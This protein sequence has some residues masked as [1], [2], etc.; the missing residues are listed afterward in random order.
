MQITDRI[1]AITSI[2]PAYR[3]ALLPAP[4]SVKIE[5]TGRCNF[6]CSFCARSMKL[7]GQFDMDRGLFERL[8]L[9]MREAGVEELGL[10]YLG[11]SMLLPWLAEACAFAKNTA[12]FPYVFLTTN[13]SLASPDKCEALFR[14]GLDSLKFSLNYADSDQFSEIARVKPKLYH[15]MIANIKAV[16][17]VRDR[18][19]IDT[20]HRCGLYAS[21]IEYDGAQGERMKS[22]VNEL[23]GC[24][25]QIYGLPLYSQAELVGDKERDKGWNVTAGN[26]GRLDAL[27]EPL[28]CWSVFT[29]GHITWD[30]KLS[31]CCFDHDGR[32]EMG[33]L[34][35]TGFMDCWNSAEFQELRAA[36]LKKDVC[37]TACEKCVAYA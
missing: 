27:R 29:E 15:Q 5:L 32:F 11:E 2:A 14:A 6:A 18:V 10:F 8:A 31:A 22:V 20:N 3:A 26:R 33:D 34:N 30:G 9:E 13:G 7:R 4:K 28:P 35:N 21:Y 16:K 36:H 23:S 1:D 12:K 25:D 37:G 24:V 17:A 19:W